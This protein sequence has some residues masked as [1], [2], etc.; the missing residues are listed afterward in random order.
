[1]QNYDI[2]LIGGGIIG[3][4]TARE[5]ALAGASVIVIEAGAC[6]H[7]AS[8]AAGGIVS[9]LYPWRY[10]AAITALAQAAQ[11]AYPPLCAQLLADTG[12]DPEW[13]RSGLLLLAIAD[14]ADAIRWAGEQGCALQQL[15]AAGIAA[16]QPDLVG[17]VSEAVFFP[18]VAQVRN[19]R[20]LKALLADV[21]QRGVAV[22]EHSP[23]SGFVD[24]PGRERIASA[25][26]AQGAITA[27]EF[28]VCAGAWSGALLAPHLSRVAI[29][30]VKGQ[31]LMFAPHAHRL[32]RIVLRD[33]RYLIPRRD[34]R[35]ICG[36]TMEHSGFDKS[37]SAE[38][39][40]SLWQAAV[41][42]MPSLGE[43]PVEMQWAG[44]RPG[45]AS[46]IPFIGRLPTHQNLWLNTGHYRNGIVLAPAS[47]RL[48]ADML[49]DR[50]PEISPQP[51]QIAG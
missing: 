30:P 27:N 8:W 26:T 13:Q 6:G 10:P 14:Q 4:L 22:V 33:G 23:V 36:S 11:K 28:V 29:E 5:L 21:R 47:A 15:D 49:L 40:E 37:T 20:L 31:M 3:L 9:P 45:S 46:G 18:D 2:C 7:E 43:V 48:L 51:Y 34:G 44:L 12:I 17:D 25:V 1:M 38:A 19:P 35:I 42:I 32:Q 24:Q 41:A 39:R 50:P 16:T